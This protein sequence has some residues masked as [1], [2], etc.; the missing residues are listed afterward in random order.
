MAWISSLFRSWWLCFIVVVV[1]GSAKGGN[2]LQVQH[3]VDS[4][5]V[6]RNSDPCQNNNGG[7]S[8]MCVATVPSYRCTCPTGYRLMADGKACQDKDECLEPNACPEL[9]Q[10]VNTPGSYRCVCPSGFA[11]DS[12]DSSCVDIDECL[13]GT[14][15]CSQ[16]CHNTQGSYR[17][18][19]STGFALQEDGATCEDIDE[20][21]EYSPCNVSC[22]NFPGSYT[23]SCGEGQYY[24][25]RS[26]TCV[27]ASCAALY[28][29]KLVTH[30]TI[31]EKVEY[32]YGEV[33]TLQCKQ[34]VTVGSTTVE[35]TGS[36]EWS[37]VMADCVEEKPPS[38]PPHIYLSSNT[39]QEH[40]HR[41]TA[42]GWLRTMYVRD[43]PDRVYTLHNH[44][45]IFGVYGSGHDAKLVVTGNLDFELQPTYWLNI[46]ASSDIPPNT[47][48]NII[49]VH[50]SDINEPPSIP[51]LNSSIL[52]ETASVGTQVTSVQAVDPDRGQNLTYRIVSGAHDD[53]EFKDNLLLVKSSLDFETREL[54]DIEIEVRDDGIP[55]LATRGTLRVFVTNINEAPTSILLNS[56]DVQEYVTGKR[57]GTRNGTVISTLTAVDEDRNDIHTFT[58]LDPRQNGLECFSI[59][60]SYLVVGNENCF[61]YET[62][63]VLTV[64]LQ[65]QDSGF[66]TYTKTKSISILDQ[67][68]APNRV[69]LSS[70]QIFSL[71]PAGTVVGTLSAV[72]PDNGD[73]HNFTLTG[74]SQQFILEGNKLKVKTD[75]SLLTSPTVQVTI[76]ATDLGGLPCQQS[77]TIGLIPVSSSI[78]YG[79]ADYEVTLSPSSVLENSAAGTEV[80]A[81]SIVHHGNGEVTEQFTCVLRDD[82]GGMF[83]VQDRN[84]IAVSGSTLIDFESGHQIQIQVECFSSSEVLHQ[85]F[86]I[87]ILNVNEPPTDIKSETGKF[88]VMENKMPGELIAYL[89]AEDPDQGDQFRFML[90]SSFTMVPFAI[91]A[92]HLITHN[93]INFELTPSF[94]IT[95][96][97]TDNGGLRFS[98]AITVTVVDQNDPPTQILMADGTCIIES[99]AINSVVTTLRTVDEDVEQLHTYT[100]QDQNPPGA[101]AIHNRNKL[102][103]ADASK[104]DYEKYHSVEVTIVTQDNGL[105]LALSYTQTLTIP[106][107]DANESPTRISLDNYTVAENSPPGTLVANIHVEDPDTFHQVFYC[108]LMQ[109]AI[110]RFQIQFVPL[111]EQNL[112]VVADGSLLNYEQ[113]D[114]HLIEIMCKDCG[115]L[116][117][118]SSFS[119]QVLDINDAPLKVI[120]VDSKGDTMTAP[121]PPSETQQQISHLPSSYVVV[122]NETMDPSSI[123][124]EIVAYFSVMDDDSLQAGKQ[125]HT[126]HLV[127]EADYINNNLEGPASEMSSRFQLMTLN[128]SVWN[129]VVVREKLDYEEV[130]AVFYLYLRCT[131]DGIPTPLAV[132]ASL[133]VVVADVPEAPYNISLS[134][135]NILENSAPESTVG[136][137]TIHDEDPPLSG[138]IITVTTSG[139]PFYVRGQELKVLNNRL[140][141]ELKSVFTVQVEAKEVETGLSLTKNF[142]I[143]IINVDEPPCCLQI[144]GQTEL[145]LP[146][147]MAVGTEIGTLTVVDQDVG[148]THTFSFQ[149]DRKRRD[150]DDHV[151]YFRLEGN[152]LYLSKALDPLSY[153]ML[154]ISILAVDS[155]GLQL[156]EQLYFK[157]LMINCGGVKCSSANG[158]CDKGQLPPSCRCKLG[159]EG[160]GINCTNIDE[161]SPISPCHP[162]NSLGCIDGYGGVNN[163]TCMCKDGWMPPN[164]EQRVDQ[165]DTAMCSR[166]GTSSCVHQS[167]GTQCVCKAG[168]TGRS[169]DIDVDDCVPGV[170]GNGGQCQDGISG[171]SCVCPPGYEGRH[172]EIDRTACLTVQCPFN[173]SCIVLSG[174]GGGHVC[175]CQ[176]PYSL[177]CR[178]CAYGYGGPQCKPCDSQHTG[179]DCKIKTAVC[180]SSPCEHNSTCVD[181]DNSRFGCICAGGWTGPTC[182]KLSIK[183]NTFYVHSQPSQASGTEGEISMVIYVIIG[184]L[185]FLLTVLVVIVTFYMVRRKRKKRSARGRVRYA[186]SNQDPFVFGPPRSICADS[187]RRHSWE[188][189]T[190]QFVNPVYSSMESALAANVEV[191]SGECVAK[192]ADQD[193]S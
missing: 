99:A 50:I 178:G 155:T 138:Y 175:Q 27:P 22:I 184:I 45:D 57:T 71:S 114:T 162:E 28:M 14:I 136:L 30:C 8:Y 97:V 84:R 29:E 46:S 59:Y 142:T 124:N 58:V 98:K 76:Q 159:F 31:Q 24:S 42:I 193:A 104:I 40:S 185:A 90:E 127:S 125:K 15:A 21:I 152:K 102:V 145:E 60:E 11:C 190:Q 66:L 86:V 1:I 180:S 157:V 12:R 61:D 141:Y 106:V 73:R 32:D 160:N 131:D 13:L 70:D 149:P 100:I 68:E 80:G 177:D 189:E 164:C 169:C 18:V 176:A 94:D 2:L 51:L 120:F 89:S 179:Y 122:V 123:G 67:N 43:S 95:I 191:S 121:Y 91:G 41:M 83:I 163:Y 144:N 10:C 79:S 113:S 150:L 44:T 112:L 87:T 48:N 170:C 109:D 146:D 93:L 4:S 181:L 165:C 77:L 133:K 115:G 108:T 81:V 16:G 72:D 171:Y 183:S 38:P 17:C 65:V 35:C 126:C 111:V 129:A 161:C 63:R 75:L 105:P 49:T 187:E 53:F 117:V 69:V 56:S 143:N 54:Y 182:S 119:V 3:V 85:T 92:N 7:C 151:S 88:E 147:N 25:S 36:G 135:N 39:I 128:G 137:L 34:G 47:I 96:F 103:V 173:G 174:P 20:C 166:N 172:C 23:C 156:L 5:R 37:P 110:G 188:A 33:C 6:R 132:M 186:S 130:V 9:G 158:L 148:D 107:L 140:N 82:G 26:S 153:A 55:S 116:N 134:N 52:A 62:N 78:M 192:V 101:L 154:G 167:T 139:T 19:C 118:S 168:Y 64:Q 74:P